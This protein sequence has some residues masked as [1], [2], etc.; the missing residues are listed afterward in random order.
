MKK[1][2]WLLLAGVLLLC[3]TTCKKGQD[4]FYGLIEKYR[5]QTEA[6]QSTTVLENT[7]EEK[8]IPGT[9]HTY[10]LIPAQDAPHAKL[11]TIK[12][13]QKEIQTIRLE[14]NEWF[15]AEPIYTDVTFDGRQDI[16]VPSRTAA[17]GAFFAGYIW[18]EKTGQY[19]YAPAI[20]NIPNIALDTQQELLLSHRT[21]SQSTS[22]GMDCYNSEKRDFEPVRSLYWEPA[23]NDG[24]VRVVESRY[25][26]GKE[27]EVK[28]FSA[29]AA[30]GM[31]ADKTDAN[32]APYYEAGSVWDLDSGK[33]QAT[34][35]TP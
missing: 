9:G 28:R 13:G 15:I 23:E 12:D 31:N 10:T 34:L 2:L 25:T 30:D 4:I 22:Y 14:G 6:T 21:G 7:G 18:D 17:S 5:P 24:Y 26:D 29:T 19:V 8:N 32:M 1:Y 35:Y 27:A 16:L 3:L 20:E 33:W 11:L